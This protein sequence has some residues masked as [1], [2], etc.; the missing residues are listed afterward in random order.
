MTS[1][2]A[3]LLLGLAGCGSVDEPGV[4]RAG[5]GPSGTLLR[6]SGALPE[7]PVIVIYRA[8][9]SGGETWDATL[10]ATMAG[11][12]AEGATSA[13]GEAIAPLDWRGNENGGRFL[14]YPL[15]ATLALEYEDQDGD[16]Y[17]SLPACF[18]VP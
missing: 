9:V 18:D 11:E 16:V 10:E 7:T 4:E 14:A 15:G 8:T 6:C 1:R 2:V 3:I 17:F 5:V 12:R 13:T